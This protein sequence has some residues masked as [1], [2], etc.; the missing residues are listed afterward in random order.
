MVRA[1]RETGEAEL[2]TIGKSTTSTPV[3]V[4]RLLPRW[5][6]PESTGPAPSSTR[7][8]PLLHKSD[9]CVLDWLL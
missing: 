6:R 3:E 9:P 7:D 1:R 2:D 8:P 5:I 4:K